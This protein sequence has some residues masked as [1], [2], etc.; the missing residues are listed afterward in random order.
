M[1]CAAPHT[2]EPSKD[3]V[4]IVIKSEKETSRV[5]SRTQEPKSFKSKDPTRKKKKILE[6]SPFKIK[7]KERGFTYFRS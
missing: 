3:S 2:S 7:K 6:K 1:S 4:P 5:T